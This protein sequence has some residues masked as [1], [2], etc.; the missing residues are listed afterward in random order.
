MTRDDDERRPDSGGSPLGE[1]FD[2][3]HLV[4]PD[5]VRELDADVRAYR[6][7]QRVEARKRRLRALLLWRR[8]GLPGW[9][10][11][12]T[13]FLLAGFVSLMLLFP[14]SERETAKPDPLAAPVRAEGEEGGLV[15]DVPIRRDKNHQQSLRS[16]RP[17]IVML[18][19]ERCDCGSRSQT[20]AK[21]AQQHH[22][23]SVLVGQDV[24]SRPLGLTD[25]DVVRATDP[26]G[27][28]AAHYK[29]SDR[30]VLLFVRSDGV[31][32]R[33]LLDVPSPNA[34]DGELAVISK[35]Q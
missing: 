23:L 16:L 29:L 21:A 17:A 26:T 14:T 28:L 4:V 15:L 6:R 11:I 34:L 8:F 20:V 1:P 31:I 5:D 3:E 35:H 32:N 18:L 30:P 13:A 33:I 27:T 10:I 22:V 2:W 9:V 25:S 19:P 12:A 24:P 7:E